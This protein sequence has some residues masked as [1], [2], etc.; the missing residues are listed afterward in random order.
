MV[1]SGVPQRGVPQTG[2]T[3]TRRDA[4]DHIAATLLGSTSRLTRLLLRSGSRELSR[5]EAGL[6]TTLTDGPRR[7]T[8]LAETEALAQPSVSKLV[9][10]LERRGLVG[11]DRAPDDGRAV[12]VSIS[13]EGRLRLEEARR[14]LRS[15]LR[16]LLGELENDDLSALTAAGEAVERLI[17]ILQ[18]RERRV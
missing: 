15:L 4:E 7:I 8:E 6:L 9:D 11:R 10:K 3:A 16:E 18:R 1:Q 17:E 12:V 13:D 2:V 5:T 14:H